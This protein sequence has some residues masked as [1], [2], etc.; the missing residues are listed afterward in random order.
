LMAKL[1]ADVKYCLRTGI[2]INDDFHY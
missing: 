1:Q 2:G